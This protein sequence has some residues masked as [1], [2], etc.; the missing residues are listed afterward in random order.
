MLSN[1][2]DSCGSLLFLPQLRL[3]EDTLSGRQWPHFPCS[4]AGVISQPLCRLLIAVP[5]TGDCDSPWPEGGWVSHCPT[6][7]TTRTVQ[8]TQ[9]RS[10]QRVLL[11]SP[12]DRELLSKTQVLVFRSP[13]SGG[14]RH[15][16]STVRGPGSSE[17][18]QP[19]R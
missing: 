10:Q 11:P 15:H 19:G 6:L 18:S 12:K 9:S 3:W 4:A 1:R 17:N 8:S 16:T 5:G 2:P 13:C 14:R 7:L